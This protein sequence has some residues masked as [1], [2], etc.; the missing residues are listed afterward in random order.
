VLLALPPRS[1]SWIGALPILALACAL[2]LPFLGNPPIFDDWVFFNGWNFAYYATHPFDLFGIRSL[3]YFSL[4]FTFVVSSGMEPHRIVT[5][6]LHA[7]CSLALYKLLYDLLRATLQASPTEAGRQ[8]ERRAALCAMIGA[9]AFAIHPMAV[10]GA[11]YLMQRTIVLAT[12]FS[13]LSLVLFTRGLVQGR[14]ADALS[15]AAMY[16]L[17]VYSKEHSLLLPAAAVLVVPLTRAS[18]R[19]SARHAGLYLAACAPAAILVTLLSKGVIGR[20][21]EPDIGVVAMQMERMF[22]HSIAELSWVLSAVT[23]AGLFFKYLALWLLPRTGAM[24]IDLRVDFFEQWSAFWIVVKVAAFAGFAAIALFLLRRRGRAGLVGFG[25]LYFWILFLVEFSVARFQ[26]PF[27]LYRSYL[28]APGIMLALGALLSAVPVRASLVGFA[29]AMPVL[30]YQA[31][32]RLVVASSPVLL[33]EDAVAKLPATPVPWGTRTLYSLTAEY[34]RTGK[35]EKATEIA[36]RC[37]AQYPDTPHCH[38]ARGLIYYVLGQPEL[39][40]PHLAR[41]VELQPDSG[42][43]HHRLGLVV[44]RLGH[45]EQAK[46]LYQRASELGFKSAD[47]EVRRLES[48]TATP[49]RR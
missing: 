40:A 22:G 7:A 25:M 24:S 43:A 42:V 1:M 20:A 14:H 21:Y 37:M 44:E 5:L 6:A 9:C 26:E 15:A 49:V 31:H 18:W 12:L 13:L 34:M 47:Y 46:A 32:D 45:A 29:V 28:W 17:A 23:Q 39:A 2:Y 16:T 38:Y 48:L 3:P 11:G 27:V 35:S 41:A 8:L 33:W 19:F 30:L 10:Y 36:D 4:A